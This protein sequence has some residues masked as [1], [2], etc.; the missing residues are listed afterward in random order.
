MV[1]EYICMNVSNIYM[2]KDKIQD[3]TIFY[4]KNKFLNTKKKVS[5]IKLALFN[6]RAK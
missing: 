4:K 6:K 5:N 3:S 1:H 2:T